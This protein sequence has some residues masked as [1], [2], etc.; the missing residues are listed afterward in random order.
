MLCDSPLALYTTLPG[1]ILPIVAEAYKLAATFGATSG[2]ESPL[3]FDRQDKFFVPFSDFSSR[4]RPG[5]EIRIY[6]R[7]GGT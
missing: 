7:R 6:R 5:P 1:D 4:V 3:I 2:P